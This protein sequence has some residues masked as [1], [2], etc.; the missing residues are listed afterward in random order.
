MASISYKNA[1]GQ[2]I[3]ISKV[4]YADGS[5][6]G[7][8]KYKAL[9][10]KQSD[11]TLRTYWTAGITKLWE[12]P[13]VLSAPWF[14]KEATKG[15]IVV[16][17]STGY[18]KVS[19]LNG[20]LT[21]TVSLFKE[22]TYDNHYYYIN[23]DS[24][25]DYPDP[26]Y[27]DYI[28]WVVELHYVIEEYDL[29]GNFIRTINEETLN[30]YGTYDDFS[31]YDYYVSVLSA[32]M[33]HGSPDPTLYFSVNLQVETYSSGTAVVGSNYNHFDGGTFNADRTVI[34]DNGNPFVNCVNDTAISVG[35]G[36]YIGVLWNPITNYK[37]Q[38]NGT[39]ITYSST[40]SGTSFTTTSYTTAQYSIIGFD[41]SG[42]VYLKDSTKVY[43]MNST[44]STI[45]KSLDVVTGNLYYSYDTGNII[46]Y[47]SVAQK[48]IGYSGF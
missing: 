35:A 7:L 47:D 23:A 43:K 8:D 27:N 15:D 4:Q 1:S 31:T 46:A 36:T 10:V 44:L 11:G 6:A 17:T 9:E 5:V 25:T 19:P 41:S 45:I 20:T 32:S 39:Y 38:T 18:K 13:N 21:N 48:L 26:D 24:P 33:P 2:E 14:T 34:L 40:F 16:N 42:N 3:T 22:S 29:Q 12:V 30:W 37:Y 28:H